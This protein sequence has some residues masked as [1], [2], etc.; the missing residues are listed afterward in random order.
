MDCVKLL[1]SRLCFGIYRLFYEINDLIK[2]GRFLSLL[3]QSCDTITGFVGVIMMYTGN[4][5]ETLNYLCH[6]VMTCYYSEDI[7]ITDP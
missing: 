7:T 2:I 3:Y 5:I 1:H 6:A 4:G